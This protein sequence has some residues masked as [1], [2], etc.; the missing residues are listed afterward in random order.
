MGRLRERNVRFVTRNTRC[1]ALLLSTSEVSMRGCSQVSRQV[2]V[3]STTRGTRLNDQT[4]SSLTTALAPAEMPGFDIASQNYAS[5]RSLT[6]PGESSN[7]DLHFRFYSHTHTHT[8]RR[9]VRRD[10]Q[11]MYCTVRSI[12]RARDYRRM[13]ILFPAFP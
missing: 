9:S 2:R 4:R 3:E 6:F 8:H 12:L 10:C 13:N 5:T 1:A 7:R 11:L